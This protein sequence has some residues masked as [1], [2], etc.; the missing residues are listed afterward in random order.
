MAGGRE[1]RLFRAALA[2]LGL[3]GLLWPV[4]FRLRPRT[5]WARMA[6]GAGSLGLYALAVRPEL[7]RERTTMGDAVSGAASAAGLYLIFQIGDR[8]ARRIMPSG[9]EDIASIYRLRSVASRPL[10]AA[11]LATVIAPSEEL[12][13]RGLVQH[14]FMRRWGR[15]RGYM[16]ASAAYGTV[17]LASGNL[18]LT[19]AATM[20]GAYWGIDYAWR[21]RLGPLLVSHI[22]WDVWIFLIQPTPGGKEIARGPIE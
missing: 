14:A 18:T 11:L 15:A 7:R 22:L 5:F 17:H 4:V 10:I 13:W 19:G 8:F 2:G 21:R 3:A 1:D 6:I 12:F 16:A 20:A 9:E